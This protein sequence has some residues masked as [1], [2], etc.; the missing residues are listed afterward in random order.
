MPSRNATKPS[1]D[2]K[3]FTQSAKKI[4][5]INISPVTSRGGI[6]L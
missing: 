3:I 2:K 6:R 4:K 5:K 1:K